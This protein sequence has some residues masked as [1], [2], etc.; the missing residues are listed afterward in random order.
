[1]KKFMQSRRQLVKTAGA[2]AA[3]SFIPKSI[4]NVM[5]NKKANFRFSINTSTISGQKPGVLKYID[6]ASKAGYDGIELWVRDVVEYLNQGNSISSLKKLISDSG[7]TVENAIGFATW[8]VD[9]E[10]QRNAA[11][12]QMKEEMDIMAQLG[13]KRIA[14]CAKGL[15]P[16][17]PFDLYKAG[18]RYKQIIELGRQT[19]VMPQLEFWGHS[20]ALFH[21]GQAMMIAAIA[22]DPEVHIL[23]DVYHMFRGSSGFDSLKML[24][25]NV[26]EIFHMNDY[27][28]S[29]PREQQSDKDRVYPGDGSAPMHQILT[30]LSNMGGTK[31][32]SIELFNPDYWQQDPYQVA[33]TGLDKMK[34]LV[35]TI[36]LL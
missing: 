36:A 19:G 7:L 2:A 32:L 3:L 33:K 5:E 23:A 22:D 9:D 26:I 14:A 12:A 13:C 4:S 28:T 34:T 16:G 17:D 6:I 20:P 31:V 29:I 25:G 18:A 27:I 15:M 1:M 8:L 24:R 35:R 21:L 11:F 10:K 30:D